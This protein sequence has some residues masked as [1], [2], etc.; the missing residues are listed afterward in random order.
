MTHERFFIIGAQ[1]SGTTYLS[2]VLDEHPAVLMARPFKPE[3][4]ALLSP[5][6]DR[7]HIQEYH[8]KFFGNDN[9]HQI[10]GEKSTSYYEIENVPSRIITHFPKASLIII[11]RNPVHRAL[12]NFAFSTS[13]GF[14]TRSLRDVF[15]TKKPKPKI[16][17]YVSVDPFDYLERGLYSRFIN[18]Y[19][20]V[21]GE[22][23]LKILIMEKFIGNQEKIS[24]LY[25]FLG[26]TPAFTPKIINEKINA[27]EI[28]GADIDE[29]V[30]IRLFRYYRKELSALESMFNLDLEVWRQ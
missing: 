11:L 10:Y 13:N 21:F 25:H 15:I 6:Y 19:I 14:E 4:K 1:R 24:D 2:T 7:F 26:V 28:A 20:K 16:R 29:E 27:G 8:G 9:A 30:K 12:S 5:F 18:R 3:P 22:K 23:K 17:S